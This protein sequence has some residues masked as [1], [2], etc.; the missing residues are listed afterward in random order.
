[1]HLSLDSFAFQLN[2]VRVVAESPGGPDP[3]LPA[4]LGVLGD[5]LRR[6]VG[7]GLCVALGRGLDGLPARRRGRSSHSWRAGPSIAAETR[8]AED[9]ATTKERIS[10]VVSTGTHALVVP[11]RDA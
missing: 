4:R 11:A 7:D 10:S 1:M 5:V 3:G 9:L 2:A 6:P 8:F